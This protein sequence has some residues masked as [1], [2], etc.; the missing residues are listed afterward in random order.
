MIGLANSQSYFSI[1]LVYGLTN[2]E[3]SFGMHIFHSQ[4]K[5]KMDAITCGIHSVLVPAAHTRQLQPMN[6]SVDIVVKSLNLCTYHTNCSIPIASYM[7]LI[8]TFF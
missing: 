3:H 4:D 2:Y 1:L 8:P 6:V 7:K 5:Q